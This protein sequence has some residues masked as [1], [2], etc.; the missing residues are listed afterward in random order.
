[1]PQ[2]TGEDQN[3]L[4]E[5]TLILVGSVVRAQVIRFGHLAGPASTLTLPASLIYTI[6]KL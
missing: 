5:L 3:L 1:M 6:F 2:H 4:W